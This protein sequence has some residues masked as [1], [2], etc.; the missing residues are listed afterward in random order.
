MLLLSKVTVELKCTFLKI[1]DIDTINQQ[2]EAE[3]FVQAKWEEPLLQQKPG[4]DQ[5]LVYKSCSQWYFDNKTREK[6]Q[7]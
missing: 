4:K 1:S 7:L 2:F 5:V 6:S 3:I